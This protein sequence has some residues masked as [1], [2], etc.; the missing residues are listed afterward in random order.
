MVTRSVIP[1]KGMLVFDELEVEVDKDTER[2]RR[3]RVKEHY[4]DLKRALI[5]GVQKP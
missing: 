1:I 4:L 5:F 3:R 2:D